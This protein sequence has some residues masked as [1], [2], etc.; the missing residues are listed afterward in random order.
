M[1]HKGGV[2]DLL[3]NTKVCRTLTDLC[4]SFGPPRQILGREALDSAWYGVGRRHFRPK[5]MPGA[6]TFPLTTQQ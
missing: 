3:P 5:R 1:V 4:N 2:T 6:L